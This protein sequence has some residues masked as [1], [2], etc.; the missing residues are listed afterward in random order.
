MPLG[1]GSKTAPTELETLGMAAQI[2][3]ALDFMHENSA[4]LIHRTPPWDVFKTQSVDTFHSTTQHSM[5]R[6]V[7][8][9]ILSDCKCK[10]WLRIARREHTSS[11]YKALSI[12][13]SITI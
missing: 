10:Y 13:L 2:L 12:R 9:L 8:E 3:R 4:H 5:H 1:S 6:G 11:Q 7:C